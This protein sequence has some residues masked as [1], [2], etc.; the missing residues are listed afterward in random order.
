VKQRISVG[1]LVGGL[2]LFAWGAAAHTA[3]P[4][5]EAGILS[6]PDE[7]PVLEAMK[8][9]LPEDG[10]Y[11]FPGFD[12]EANDPAAEEA[13]NAKY[14][15]GPHGLVVF[16]RQGGEPLSARQL[17]TEFASNVF[18]ALMGAVLVARVAG[19]FLAR[20]LSVT[21]L[22]LFATLSIDVSYWNWY[23]FPTPFLLAAFVEQAVGAMLL[24]LVLAAI[25]RPRTI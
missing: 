25:V 24:G 6:M 19:G 5:G 14:R 17:L 21:L 11:F 1:A 8:A 4:L 10:L 20:A 15:V 3:L 2:V 7:G 12:P 9:G 13:W 16:H 22:G 18:A 23:G